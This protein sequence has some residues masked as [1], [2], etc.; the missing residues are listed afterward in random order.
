MCVPGWFVLNH[1]IP[2]RKKEK[3]TMSHWKKWGT[4]WI[5][6]GLF[7]LSWFAHGVVQ[8]IVLGEDGPAF[9]HSTLEN[10]QSE[11]LQLLVQAVLVVGLAEKLFQ[12]SME[13]QNRI[14]KKIDDMQELMAD[15]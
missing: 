15:L 2:S 3:S 14:E 7:V 11:W 10:W 12:K 1:G 4:A 13:Q 5:L 6:L 8:L 9:W